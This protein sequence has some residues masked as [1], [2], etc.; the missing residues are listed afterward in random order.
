M[1]SANLSKPFVLAA[2]LLS[3]VLSPPL[4]AQQLDG[5]YVYLQY[6]VIARSLKPDHY[7]FQPDGRY[8]NNA[9]PTEISKAG[10]ENGCKARPRDCGTYRLSGTTLTLTTHDGKSSNATFKMLGPEKVEMFGVEGTKVTRGFPPG[11]KLNGRYSATSGYGDIMSARGYEFH[12]DGSFTFDSVAAVRAADAGNGVSSTNRSGTY[13]LIGNTLELTINGQP[14]RL[15]AY[16]LGNLDD[17][18]MIEGQPYTK[19]KK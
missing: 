7:F 6:Q 11:T 5:L 3:G 9:P 18:I 13:R 17:L 2:A 8:L 15:L 16:E 12:P 19:K 10:F 14:T 1:Q 4:C